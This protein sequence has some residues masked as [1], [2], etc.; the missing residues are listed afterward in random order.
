MLTSWHSVAPSGACGGEQNEDDAPNSDTDPLLH[1]YLLPD[2]SVAQRL[3]AAFG[4]LLQLVLVIFLLWLHV[5][6]VWVL[7][8]EAL[9]QSYAVEA[10]EEGIGFSYMLLHDIGRVVVGLVMLLYVA[11]HSKEEW[12][13]MSACARKAAAEGRPGLAA[14]LL[15]SWGLFWGLTASTGFTFLADGAEQARTATFQRRSDVLSYLEEL[16]INSV[17]LLF[18]T[19]V[20]SWVVKL[21]PLFR[22]RNVGARM[23]VFS[24]SSRGG[25]GQLATPPTPIVFT[26]SAAM[27]G[28][29][30]PYAG[31]Q[32][33]TLQNYIHTISTYE[34]EYDAAGPPS[35]GPPPLDTPMINS[36]TVFVLAVA[37]AARVCIMVLATVCSAVFVAW[38]GTGER[39]AAWILQT[40]KKKAARAENGESPLARTAWRAVIVIVSASNQSP[41][42]AMIVLYASLLSQQGGGSGGNSSDRRHRRAN[43]SGTG[44]PRIVIVASLSSL[45]YTTITETLVIAAY[46]G[47]TLLPAL[48]Y[49][50]V[51]LLMVVLLFGVSRVTWFSK[52]ALT[53]I[54][55][56]ALILS[57]GT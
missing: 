55:A 46:A 49:L 25:P 43:G 21:M 42:V 12:P 40:G 17:G 57:S 8:E 24:T 9:P 10:K 41:Q 30:V 52:A 4:I 32:G 19:E 3:L 16:V 7:Q 15:F 48:L 37:Y 27:V 5:A 36:K 54:L 44:V 14:G 18:V 56:V 38:A 33:E 6:R 22:H 29:V 39:P 20:D 47:D 11:A 34:Q 45:L 26:L 28:L 35:P 13:R 31:L 51:H 50:A 53:A 23:S 1:E 2:C